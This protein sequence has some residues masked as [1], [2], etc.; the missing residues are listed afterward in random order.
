[1]GDDGLGWGQLASR[2]TGW[3]CDD[4]E[5]NDGD[6]EGEYDDGGDVRTMAIAMR[7]CWS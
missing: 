2:V 4:D 7:G 3:D 5:E 1:M 6:D